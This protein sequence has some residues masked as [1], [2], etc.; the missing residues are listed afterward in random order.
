MFMSYFFDF[1]FLQKSVKFEIMSQILKMVLK[2]VDRL[3]ELQKFC[4][5]SDFR[6]SGKNIFFFRKI[7]L[8]LTIVSLYLTKTSDPRII[9][10]K[11]R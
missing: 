7:N 4:K 9:V 10:K 3:L 8:E 2:P 5:Q 1:E 6:E 11:L